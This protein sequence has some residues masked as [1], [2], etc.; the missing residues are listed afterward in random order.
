M[1]DKPRNFPKSSV[2]QPF[3]EMRVRWLHWARIGPSLCWIAL[4]TLTNAADILHLRGG[5]KLIGKVVSDDKSKVVFESQTLGRIQVLRERI[6][7]IEFETTPQPDATAES[8]PKP[9][10]PPP[11]TTASPKIPTS[12]STNAPPQSSAKSSGFW[13]FAKPASERRPD[14]IQLKSGEWLRGEL[15]GMQ[16]RTLEFESDELD[17]LTFDWKDIHQVISQQALVSFGDRQSAWGT[18]R[19]DRENV[20]VTGAQEVVVPRHEIV[21]IAPGSP[22]EIDY[23]SGRFSAGLNLRS[24]NT[25]Q[26]DLVAKARLDRRTSNTHLDLEYVGNFS[27]L[28]GANTVNNHR[29]TESFDVFLTRRLFI[30]TPQ[31]EYYRDP[32]QNIADRLT[33]AAGVG[34][35]L[36]DKPKTEWLI[37]GGPGYRYIRFD[38][39]QSGEPESESTPA[40]AFQ[41]ALEIDLNKR[42]DLEFDYQLIVANENSGGA[43]HHGGATVEIELTRVLDLDLTFSWDHISDPQADAAGL[44]PDK[45]DF[46]LNV[47]FG[48]KF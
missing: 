19:V 28:E 16:N 33:V 2:T 43:T 22:R 48:V 32:F 15:Q 9:F 36:I 41:S 26:S 4:S 30:R 12:T 14:W 42:T 31:S 37:S 39:V 20:T 8:S 23:W 7:R 24:G 44:L 25:E 35:Y 1:N 38:T 3:A 27:E 11:P 29:A 46:R 47:S 13:S 5:E 34:Y 40:V 17:D 45:D 6:E 18:V 10:V 21:G